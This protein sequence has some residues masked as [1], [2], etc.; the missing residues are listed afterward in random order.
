MGAL[1]FTSWHFLKAP[2]GYTPVVQQCME[3]QHVCGH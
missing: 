3:K 2:E 1:K